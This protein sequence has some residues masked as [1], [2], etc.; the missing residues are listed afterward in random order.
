MCVNDVLCCGAEPLFFLDYVAMS[1]DDPQLLEAIVRGMSDGCV[2]SDMA[3][4]GGETAIM[5]DLYARGDYDLAGFCVGVVEQAEGARRLDD[6]AGRRGARR[7]FERR[8]IRTATAW[9][10]RLCSTWRG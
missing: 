8:C 1:H 2:E 10:G 9:C 7:R 4:V 5:P 3:L 6:L